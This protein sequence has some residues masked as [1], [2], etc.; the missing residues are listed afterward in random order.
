MN[1][2]YFRTGTRTILNTVWPIENKVEKRGRK[3]LVTFGICNGTARD[4]QL[5]DTKAEALLAA[6]GADAVLEDATT[7]AGLVGTNAADSHLRGSR[8]TDTGN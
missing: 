7:G 3:W 6:G 4:S 2:I 1:P 8:V 5:F